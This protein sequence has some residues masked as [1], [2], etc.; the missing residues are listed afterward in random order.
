MELKKT[1]K[2]ISTSLINDKELNVLNIKSHL[3]ATFTSVA[4]LNQEF[5]FVDHAF[6]DILKACSRP[7]LEKTSIVLT[8]HNSVYIC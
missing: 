4:L 6:Q 2:G 7:N 3:L 8:Y 5:W 1:I